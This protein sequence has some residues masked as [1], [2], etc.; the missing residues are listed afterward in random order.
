[1]LALGIARLDAR[2][3]FDIGR[4]DFGIVAA[5][6]GDKARKGCDQKQE[7]DFFHGANYL[8]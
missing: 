5:R 2:H 7:R 8:S 3:G 1:M 6:Y 4:N